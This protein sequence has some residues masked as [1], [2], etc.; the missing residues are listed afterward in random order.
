MIWNEKIETMPQADLEK[1]QVESLVKL[2][3]TLYTNVDFYR[4]KFDELGVKPS[5]IQSMKDISKL[6]FTTKDELRETYPYGL[7][8]V[9]ESK[10]VELHQSSGTTGTR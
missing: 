4:K 1:M 6:P 10:I 3:E 9:E 2:A 7:L 8:A 5:D